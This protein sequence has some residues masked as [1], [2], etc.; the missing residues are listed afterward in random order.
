MEPG[1]RD[2]R[3]AGPGLHL[4]K[5]VVLPDRRSATIAD[6]AQLI[7]NCVA[8]RHCFALACGT[9][10]SRTGGACHAFG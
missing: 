7:E 8:G 9:A 5:Q 3:Y 10:L 2:P 6:R 1:Q 4:P